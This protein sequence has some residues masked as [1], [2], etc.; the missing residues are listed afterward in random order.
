MEDIFDQEIAASVDNV[1]GSRRGCNFSK[2]IKCLQEG[3]DIKYVTV[4]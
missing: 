1:N 3:A 4:P 2:N